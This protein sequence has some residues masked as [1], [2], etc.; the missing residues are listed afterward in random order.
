MSMCKQVSTPLASG[1]KLA[2]HIGMPLGP[3][4]AKEYKSIVGALQYLTLT[5]PDLAFAVNKVCQFLHSPTDEHWAVVKRILRYLKGCTRNGL[6]IM[7]NNS[8][9]LT[10]FS[11]ADWAGC[12][13]DRRSTGGY[14]V[15]LGTNLVSLL[16]KQFAVS[17]GNPPLVS[18]IGSDTLCVIQKIAIYSAS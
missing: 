11:D 1:V 16:Q 7:K 9:L 13:D 5:H 6:K 4:D 12:L 17:V 14:A 3:K 10:A 15:F 18:V 2:T 8:F